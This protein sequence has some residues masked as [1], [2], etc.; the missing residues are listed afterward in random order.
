MS[1][2]HAPFVILRVTLVREKVT[3]AK[4]RV[5]RSI[6]VLCEVA[7]IYFLEPHYLLTTLVRN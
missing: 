5:W 4:T 1:H 2:G 3:A 7:R 6:R